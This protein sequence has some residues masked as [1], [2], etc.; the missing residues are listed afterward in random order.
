MRARRAHRRRRV[1]GAS[2]DG[3]L[4]SSLKSCTRDRR[5]N[6]PALLYVPELEDVTLP[7]LRSISRCRLAALLVSFA[8]AAGRADAQSL[9]V[10]PGYDVY[11][12]LLG[13]PTASLPPLFTYTLTGIAQQSPEVVARYGYIPDIARPLAPAVGGHAAHSLDSFGLTGIVPV[14]LAG[15]ISLTGG[16]SN[17]RCSTGCAGARYMASAAGDYRILRTPIGPGVDAMRMTVALSGEVGI[18]SP[19]SG[20]TTTA[21]LGA[22]VALSFGRPDAT[23]IIPFITPS[24]A[25]ATAGGGSFGNPVRVAAGR[26]LLGGGVALFN[27]KS[28]LGASIGFQ[29]V[30][31]SR[32]EM[33]IGVGLSIGGR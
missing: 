5:S 17:E 8:V 26:A 32:T 3:E 25:F 19:T 10:P 20:I 33:Q 2:V 31:V 24:L 14:G 22:P 12:L 21:D 27:P 18:G 23:Q 7:R 15:A 30:F 11:L 28:A 16:V 1:L 29:Y 6:A 9:G 4:T 13:T